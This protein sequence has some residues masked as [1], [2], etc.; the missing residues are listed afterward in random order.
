VAKEP[1][2][3]E[4]R[5]IGAPCYLKGRNQPRRTHERL[6]VTALALASNLKKRTKPNHDSG[7]LPA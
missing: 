2:G 4:Q 7:E 6:P 3:R 5:M 1:G